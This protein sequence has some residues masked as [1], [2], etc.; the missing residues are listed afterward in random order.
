ML[1]RL[2]RWWLHGSAAASTDP[3][4]DGKARLSCATLTSGDA[5]HV[6]AWT[7]VRACGA[8]VVDCTEYDADRMNKLLSAVPANKI[9]MWYPAQR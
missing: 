3:P 9:V 5:G 1:Q 2:R 7:A 8:V 6:A 4:S